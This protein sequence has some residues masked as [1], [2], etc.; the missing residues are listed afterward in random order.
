MLSVSRFR[1]ALSSRRVFG[2][3]AH[4]ALPAPL[5]V[6]LVNGSR[7]VIVDWIKK[8]E[9]PIEHE[10]LAGVRNAVEQA[11]NRG[12]GGFGSEEWRETAA[13]DFMEK[14]LEAYLPVVFFAV[15]ITREF[16]LSLPTSCFALVIS[17][18]DE[19]DSFAL[20]GIVSPHTW[21]IDIDREN[22]VARTQ[23]PLALAW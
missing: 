13:S 3:N 21:C 18:R 8:G 23:I 11:R 4:T 10:S 16:E 14:Q 22:S 6:G 15:G 1:P 17:R 2:H 20:P 5:T 9:E 19:S 7:G 12:R